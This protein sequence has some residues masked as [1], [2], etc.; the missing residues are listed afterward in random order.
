MNIH[1]R[2]ADAQSVVVEDRIPFRNGKV[3]RAILL[4]SNL[5]VPIAFQSISFQ[6]HKISV[7]IRSIVSRTMCS[8]QDCS[9]PSTNWFTECP[10][11]CIDGGFWASR[12]GIWCKGGFGITSSGQG[13]KVCHILIGLVGIKNPFDV[14]RVTLRGR[15]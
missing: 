1:F 10:G 15:V 2:F 12:G 11:D 5:R 7:Y 9:I 13:I 6:I 3:Y 8:Q 4:W 14:K